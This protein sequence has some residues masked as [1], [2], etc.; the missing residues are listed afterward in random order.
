MHGYP[1]P[2]PREPPRDMPDW[3]AVHHESGRTGVTPDL[4]WQEYKAQQPDGYGYSWFCR[5]YQDWEC[6]CRSGAT[7]DGAWKD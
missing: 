1:L 6:G 4:L 5:A 2:T 7:A 3:A